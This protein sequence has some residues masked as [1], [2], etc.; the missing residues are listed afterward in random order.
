MEKTAGMIR[1]MRRPR[2]TRCRRP[3][4]VIFKGVIAR[5]APVSDPT[6]DAAAQPRGGVNT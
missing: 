2:P 5:V 6:P 3:F 4:A 1:S